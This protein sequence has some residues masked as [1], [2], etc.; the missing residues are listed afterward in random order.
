MK[1]IAIIA[2]ASAFILGACQK[3]LTNLNIDTKNPVNAPSY[4]LFTNG[5]KYMTDWLTT[6][7]VDYNITDLIAQYWT[8]TTYTDESNYNLGNRDI[9]R[10]F[11]N[12][13]YNDALNNYVQAKKL[14]PTDVTDPDQARNELDITDIMEVYT[15][16]YLVNTFGNIPYTEAN[17]ID[18]YPFPKYDDAKTIYADLLTRLDSSIA[19]LNTGAASFG[20]ADILY[21]GDVTAWKKFANSLKLKMAMLL[22]DTDPSTANTKV[23]EAIAGGVFQS[24]ADNALF[25]YT[26]VTPN[27]NPIWVDVIQSNRNDYV[28]AKT[29]LNPMV[30]FNDPRRTAYY[31]NEHSGSDKG[32]SVGDNNTWNNYSNIYWGSVKGTIVDPAAPSD[33]LDYAEVSFLLAEAVERGFI[34][35][36]A[37]TYYNNAV[38]AS[39][40]YWGGSAADAATYLAQPDVA[41]ATAPGGV[42]AG[43]IG[44]TGVSTTSVHWKQAIGMQK[45]LALYVRGLDAWTEIRRLLYPAMAVPTTPKSPFPW[46]YTYPSNEQTANGDA[47]K[48]AVT[49]MGGQ[50]AVTVKLFWMQ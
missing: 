37:A 9:P 39:I 40:E 20:A 15:Y 11:W 4:A 3:N 13:L 12:K 41:Y 49:A 18:K 23:N 1:K 29:L 50:D 17:N 22:A 36:S 32:G 38:T 8:E 31:T 14:I 6:S 33:Y 21:G 46:R 24:N 19:G 7:S 42:G 26:G 10:N 30:T 28:I 2:V 16:Y 44:S 27:A 48:A 5:Q 47:Y 34:S 35:G 43:N 45:Y 25:V